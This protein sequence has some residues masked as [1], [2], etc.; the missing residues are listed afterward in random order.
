RRDGDHALG[1]PLVPDAW[2]SPTDRLRGDRRGLLG[3]GGPRRSRRG[4]LRER[5]RRS[6]QRI[7]RDVELRRR[8]PV[9][10][11]HAQQLTE[12]ATLLDA[13]P[14]VAFLPQPGDA[15]PRRPVHD[16]EPQAPS[17]PGQYELV[18]FGPP[19][20]EHRR[21][22]VRRAAVRPPRLRRARQLVE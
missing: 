20:A 1:R 3:R 10:A 9:V 18:A 13:P 11:Y 4:V 7:R 17:L 12:L 16:P 14:I 6:R 21:D 19:A 15:P 8:S 22:V 5:G 2:R